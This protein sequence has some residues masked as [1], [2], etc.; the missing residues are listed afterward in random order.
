MS[1]FQPGL[2]QNVFSGKKTRSLIINNNPVVNEF[3]ETG[4]PWDFQLNRF[5]PN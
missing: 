2:P 5:S 3:T 4:V 1:S